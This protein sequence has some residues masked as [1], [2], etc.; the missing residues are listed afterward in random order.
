ML[1]KSDKRIIL[2]FDIKPK[3]YPS[4]LT[5]LTFCDNFNQS[6]DNLPD[7]LTHLTI[8]NCLISNFLKINKIQKMSIKNLKIFFEKLNE[9]G[10][11]GGTY[12]YNENSC[13]YFMFGG[14]DCWKGFIILL[15][16]IDHFFDDQKMPNKLIEFSYKNKLHKSKYTNEPIG[17]GVSGE[18]FFIT[19]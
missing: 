7:S 6:V 10:G 13:D 4:K 9:C 15:S 1:K 11:I 5:H 14:G 17:G 8:G 12:E 3:K 16:N 2:S 19:N 18:I